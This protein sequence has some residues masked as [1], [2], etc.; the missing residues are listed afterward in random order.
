MKLYPISWYTLQYCENF[1]LLW[2]Y[3]RE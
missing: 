3:S 1:H 2:K